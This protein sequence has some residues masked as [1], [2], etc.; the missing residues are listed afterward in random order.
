MRVTLELL[1]RY[2]SCEAGIKWLTENYPN[3]AELMDIITGQPTP[4]DDFVLW[5]LKYFSVS[6]EERAAANH[7]IETDTSTRVYGSHHTY[8]S[9]FVVNSSYVYNS[10]RVHSSKDIHDSSD[11]HST[12]G[13]REA[14][15]VRNSSSIRS[16]EFIENSQNVTSSDFVYDSNSISWSE[17]VKNSLNI[18]DGVYC[19]LC[20][21]SH[22]LTICEFVK[23][24]T[25]CCLCFGLDNKE[26]YLFNQPSTAARV[27]EVRTTIMNLLALEE[28][29]EPNQPLP[30]FFST[31]PEKVL[32]YI[33]S[34]PEYS[35]IVGASFAAVI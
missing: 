27:E 17:F 22:L 14:R 1:E 31:L 19:L 32:T 8:N 3:G 15:S 13:A 12:E 16:S 21:N 11:I 23:N 20:E 26:N 5:G 24:S 29:K 30:K 28:I 7:L 34:L 33:K 35:E 18:E 10:Q 9:D 6:D 4:P 25:N 2:E